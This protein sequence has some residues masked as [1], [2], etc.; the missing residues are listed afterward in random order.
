[1]TIT[2][3]MWVV[4]LLGCGATILL[5]LAIVGGIL[6]VDL[7]KIHRAKVALAASQEEL[8]KLTKSLNAVANANIQAA[9]SDIRLGRDPRC[10]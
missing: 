6:V 2:I 10:N 7:W 3:P 8:D 5:G 1:V 4:F 9:L